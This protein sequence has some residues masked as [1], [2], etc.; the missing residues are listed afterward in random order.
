MSVASV[1]IGLFRYVYQ[2]RLPVYVID[3]FFSLLHFSVIP[4]S[5]VC[6]GAYLLF[7]RAINLLKRHKVY[8]L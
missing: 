3:V 4:S 5:V 7:G 2:F 1:C 6:G 8:I